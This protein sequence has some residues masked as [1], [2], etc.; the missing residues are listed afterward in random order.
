MYKLIIFDLDGTI[1]N[2]LEDLADSTNYALVM[3]GFSER[4][5]EEVRTFVGNG[6][7]K[8]I[9]R[10]VPAGTGAEVAN[11]VLADFTEYY[12]KHCADKTRP[13]DGIPELIN[14]LRERGCQT[15][16]VSNKAD[17]AVQE[18]CEQYFPGLFD[19]VVG[20]RK[21]IRRKPAPD[22]VLEVLERLQVEKEE[23]LYI[24]DSEVDVQTAENAGI[25]Q[26]SVEWG[27]RTRDVL[28]SCGAEH[29]VKTPGE[30][31]ELV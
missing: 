8:L 14:V 26:I 24:G 13:Y 20:E 23:A 7:G 5:I 28:L 16:V 29:I 12:G 4:T 18:L 1:L 15:A 11:K 21:G 25:R 19:F 22:S 3:N 6:I 17:F 10:A 9:E 31:L 27:F 2:T 30:I